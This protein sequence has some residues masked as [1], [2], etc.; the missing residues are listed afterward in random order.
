MTNRKIKDFHRNA[1]VYTCIRENY[2]NLCRI[3]LT[4]NE[5]YPQ[6]VLPEESA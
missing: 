2:K 3:L 4:L 5:L 1:V 6:A